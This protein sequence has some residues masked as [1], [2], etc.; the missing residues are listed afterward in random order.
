MTLLM[1]NDA[2]PCVPTLL[3]NAVF[4]HVSQAAQRYSYG[5]E[6]CKQKIWRT[7][8]V[9][10]KSSLW[11][12]I[13][14]FGSQRGIFMRLDGYLTLSCIVPPLRA[15]TNNFRSIHLILYFLRFRVSY[16]GL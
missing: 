16:V 14:T 15:S 13:E 4:V 7:E 6:G 1:S 11:R 9:H 8:C 3:V 10:T 2:L 12:S 5:K